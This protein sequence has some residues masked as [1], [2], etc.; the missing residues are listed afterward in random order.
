MIHQSACICIVTDAS[1]CFKVIVVGKFQLSPITLIN[2]LHSVK[3]NIKSYQS[4][5]AFEFL[6]VTCFF[7]LDIM[8]ILNRHLNGN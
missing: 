2:A 3:I 1:K 5:I 6:S 4:H 7:A 8:N